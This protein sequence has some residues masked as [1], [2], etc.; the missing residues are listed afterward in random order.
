MTLLLLILTL[1]KILIMRFILI[2]TVLLLL[3]ANQVEGQISYGGRPVKVPVLKSSS[4]SIIDMPSVI[5]EDLRMLYNE[6]DS[7]PLQLKSFIFAH[8]FD[9]D[10]SPSNSGVWIRNFNGYDVWQVKVRSAGAFSLNIIFENFELNEGARLFLYNDQENHY[11]GAF[12]SENNR[13]S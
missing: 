5:N 2:V 11:L 1:A 6:L 10:I 3:Y 12:T 8:T 9:V 7:V 4:T 13:K